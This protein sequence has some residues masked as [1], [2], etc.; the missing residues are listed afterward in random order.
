MHETAFFRFD[1]SDD[2]RFYAQPRFVEHIDDGAIA[3][4]VALHREFLPA[5]GVILDCMSSWVS[6]LPPEVSYAHVAGLGM[7]AAELAANPRLDRYVV[8]DLNRDPVVPFEDETFDGIEICVSIQYLK[9]PIEVLADLA[10][11]AKP[12]AP[13]VITFSNR[14]FPTKAVTIWQELSSPQHGELVTAYLEATGRWGSIAFHDR[15]K[16]VA[17]GPPRRDPLFAVTATR[18]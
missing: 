4:V 1:E 3:A 7:N 14:C 6:H 15:S 16:R 11:V 2:A 13:L 12:G 9:R 18:I 17:G 8:H 10:R 5:G